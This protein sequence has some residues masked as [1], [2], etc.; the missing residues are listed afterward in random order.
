MSKST[1]ENIEIPYEDTTLPGHFY[2]ADRSKQPRPVIIAMTG[3]DGTKE[4]LYG[5][6]MASVEHG[7][8]CLT[9]D[10]PGQGETIRNQHLYFRPDYDK[11]VTPVVD[12]LLTR[13]EVDPKSIV[14][15]G[16]SFGGYLAPRAA[17]FEHRLAACV[18]NGGVYDFMGLRRPLDISKKEYVNYLKCN[19]DEVNKIMAGQMQTSSEMRWAISH[20]MYVFGAKSPA[21]F[22]I[23]AEDYLLEGIVEKI[24]C[25]TLVIDTENE[26]FF[27]GQAKILYNELTCRK[28]FLLFTA[29][30]GAE[31][32]CQV[33]AKRYANEHIFNWIDSMLLQ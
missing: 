24:Q 30:E 16:E 28:E 1:I 15:W 18:A 17:A 14:L 25:P 20:G 8:N 19:Q 29:E 2:Y 31:E 23:M 27:P 13:E 33:G 5:L 32:H 10:G 11:V 3:Y 26:E 12:Y 9:F 6:A 22:T 21:E 4:E 7:M